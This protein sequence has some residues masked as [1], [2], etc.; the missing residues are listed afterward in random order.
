MK[1]EYKVVIVKKPKNVEKVMN[2]YAKQGWR[3]ISN[4]YW[5]SWTNRMVLTLE[6]ELTNIDN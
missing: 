2:E 1:Y 4:A 5:S 3:V 6:R